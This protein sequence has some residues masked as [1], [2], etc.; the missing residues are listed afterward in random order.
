MGG[1]AHIPLLQCNETG[2]RQ[3]K[4]KKERW[5]REGMEDEVT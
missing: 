3:M 2:R 1:G 4:L 5:T